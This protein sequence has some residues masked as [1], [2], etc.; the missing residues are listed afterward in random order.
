M[1]YLDDYAAKKR[2][3]EDRALIM[4]DIRIWQNHYDEFLRSQP[5]GQ[6]SLTS[7]LAQIALGTTQQPRQE[8]L[9]L[10]TV[11]SSKGMEFD[12]VVIMGMTEGTFPDYRAKH[13][14]L[15]EEKRNAFVAVT[16]SKRLICF[17]YP[18]TKMMPW[19][20][21]WQQKPSRYLSDIGIIRKS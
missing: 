10:L 21:V 2:S 15:V 8:G 19:G 16:R 4:Q 14:A 18:K 11:H 13:A 3:Q 12:V 1:D 6:H 17:S 20:D 7:L 5:G 9:A